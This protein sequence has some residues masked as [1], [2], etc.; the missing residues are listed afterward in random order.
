MQ[1]LQA[2]VAIDLSQVNELQKQWFCKALEDYNWVRINKQDIMWRISFRPQ[3]KRMGAIRTIQAS[4]HKAGNA[5]GL[6]NVEYAVQMDAA[7][8]VSGNA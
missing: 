5:S 1:G 7:E 4:L 2:L 6:K 8:V 3:V